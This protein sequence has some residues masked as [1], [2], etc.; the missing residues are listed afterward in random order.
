[1]CLP[2]QYCVIL[3]CKLFCNWNLYLNGT[4]PFTGNGFSWTAFITY[5][6]RQTKLISHV[7]LLMQNVETILIDQFN[8]CYPAIFH[9]TEMR[10]HGIEECSVSKFEGVYCS[11]QFRLQQWAHQYEQTN[12]NTYTRH[13]PWPKRLSMT[14]HSEEQGERTWMWWLSIAYLVLISECTV[15][16]RQTRILT[17]VFPSMVLKVK[18]YSKALL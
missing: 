16:F 15:I 1:M 4:N 8:N 10:W 11:T 2:M 18:I 3:Y 14:I 9:T 12:V 17:A 7:K 6:I 5:Q 13:A